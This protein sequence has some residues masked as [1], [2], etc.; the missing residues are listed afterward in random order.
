M[1]AK[2]FVTFL[3][4]AAMLAGTLILPVTA[5]A[6][7]PHDRAYYRERHVWHHPAPK[8]RHYD[9]R[10]VVVRERVYTP[11]PVLRH[12]SRSDDYIVI[13]RARHGADSGLGFT[14]RD[15]WD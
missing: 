12:R 11:R 10:R 1:N 3:A 6:H 15:Y 4:T 13:P 2:R 5:S 7:D 9:D 14:H 8:W